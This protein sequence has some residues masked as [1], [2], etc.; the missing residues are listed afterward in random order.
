MVAAVEFLHQNQILHR[1][2]KPANVLVDASHEPRLLDFGL[3]LPFRDDARMTRAGQVLGTPAY[4]S[5]EQAAA[6]WR[7][8]HAAMFSPWDDAL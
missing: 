3:A 4:L 2:L 1:D 7:W 5:P 8:T 6:T